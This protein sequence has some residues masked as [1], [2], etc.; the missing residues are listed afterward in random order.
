MLMSE[1]R[2]GSRRAEH[3]GTS[4]IEAELWMSRQDA[5]TQTKAR[6]R[7]N[8]TSFASFAWPGRRPRPDPPSAAQAALSISQVQH[9]SLDSL[10]QTLTPPAV[11]SLAHAR[12]LASTLSTQSP[13]PS[14]AALNPILASLCDVNSPVAVQAAGFDILAAYL[15]NNEASVL[16]MADRISYFALFLGFK[17]AWGLELWEPRFKALRA[18]T[19]YGTDIVGNE[20][21]ILETLKS[22]IEGGFSGLLD[23]D[24][25]DRSERSERERSIDVLVKFLTTILD[26]VEII[27]R[28]P[29]EELSRVLDFYGTLVDR[30]TQLRLN[31]LSQDKNSLPSSDS[32]STNNTPSKAPSHRRNHSS[33]SVTSIPSPSSVS[34]P[35]L[36]SVSTKHPAD[37]AITLYLDHLSS[38]LKT[39]P[40]DCI[41]TILPLLFRALAFCVSPLPRL[42]I[43]PHPTKRASSEDRIVNTL[44]DLFTGPYSTT[45]MITLKK[46]LLPPNYTHAS[47]RN[48]ETASNTQSSHTV[49]NIIQTALG[50]HRTFRNYVRRA[51]SSRLARAYISRESSVGYS[52]SGAPG[53]LDLGRDL[54]E[55]AWPK[56]DYISSALGLGGNGWDAGRLGKML[57]KSVEAWVEWECIVNG[58]RDWEKE[59]DGKE[60]ILEEAAGVL[61]DIWQEL[62]ARGGDENGDS[63]SL[64][65][66]EAC[67]VGETLYKLVGY[68]LPLRYA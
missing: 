49:A 56:E 13:L 22:W 36:P 44:D 23:G 65:E 27:A 17:T 34:P 15:E 16:A 55:R 58:E 59:R 11:P 54:M 28:I 64:D 52:P 6:A 20:I 14:R 10:I 19:K 66:E 2:C 60:D 45:C 3:L 63:S 38:R 30:S 41:D 67:V 62:D 4:E 53:H 61:K 37:I 25:L 50:A 18:L 5:D 39:L 29:E 46:Y 32:T 7:A 42:S 9:L 51:L 26:N 31:A 33:I 47:T 68:V 8:T 35:A 40:P 43:L 1:V 57:T 21:A 48:P 12:A 24:V